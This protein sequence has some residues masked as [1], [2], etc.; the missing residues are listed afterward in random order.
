MRAIRTDA[1]GDNDQLREAIYEGEIFLMP[2]T[3]ASENLVAD[4]IALIEAKLGERY[5]QAQFAMPADQYLDCIADLKHHLYTDYHF[6]DSVRRVMAELRFDP[7]ENAFDP[8][9]LR[10]VTH[11]GHQN[12]DSSNAYSTH[13]DTWYA[14][15]Q[16]Q[17]N[18]WIPLHDVTEPETFCFFPRYFDKAVN[19]SSGDFDYDQWVARVGFG[20]SH[21]GRDAFYPTIPE[22]RLSE[23]HALACSCRAGEMILFSAAHLHQTAYNSSGLTRFSL[24][25]RTVNLA[26]QASR[27]G[28]PNVDNRSLGSALTDYIHPD[29]VGSAEAHQAIDD[30]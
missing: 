24:D 22:K 9:R 1:P 30:A 14:N 27:I 5:R 25:F 26:D 17:I 11:G 3:S 21:A 28:A 29:Q 6:R 13:R 18:W 23:H 2:S 12:P 16:S 7:A 10:A 19:N 20:R 15:P 4:V 8:P